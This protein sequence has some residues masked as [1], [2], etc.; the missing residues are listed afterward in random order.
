MRQQRTFVAALGL[1]AL[2]AL[3]AAPAFA[4]SSS[5]SAT[6][7]PKVAAVGSGRAYLRLDVGRN[8]AWL[9]QNIPVTISAQFR[10]VEGVT[11]EGLPQLKSDAIFTSDIARA[12]KQA[13]QIVNGEQVLVATWTG[14]ITPSTAGP[15]ALSVEL[16][17][18][19]RFHEAAPQPLAR[20]PEQEQEDPFESMMNID[21]SDPSS[22]QRIFQSMQRSLPMG[23]DPPL[24]GRAHDDAFTLKANSHPLDVQALPVAD[25]PATFGGAV[26]R[27]DIRASLS[28]ATGRAHEPLTLTV[29]VKGDGDLDRVDLPG[30]ATSADWKAYPMSAKNETAA[31]SKK[32]THKTFEQVLIPTHGGALTIPAVELPVFDPVSGHYTTVATAPIALDVDGAAEAEPPAPTSALAEIVKSAQPAPQPSLPPP[33]ASALLDSPKT[34]GLRLAPILGLL[35]GA[36]LLRFG[37]KR[38]PEKALHRALR[39]S[40]SRGS[41][42]A[43]YESAR[44]LIVVHFANRWGVTESEVTVEA[45]RT[46]LGTGAEPLVDAMSTSDALRFGRRNLEP[47]ELGALCS[48]IEESLRKAA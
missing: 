44:R 21:P 16:P 35:L 31:P 10:D 26:G 29:T 28:A 4:A 40:A 8:K 12:P 32:L 3:S 1:A 38:D 36:A 37:W 11:L 13:T 20:D 43:F 25:Q 42:G 30:I 23:F 19:I 34:I 48:S 6:T 27:F 7:S 24:V 15:L 22:I 41:A 45:L 9:G 33:A 5:A 46:Q 18:R 39:R 47:M 17:V 2:M 14:T